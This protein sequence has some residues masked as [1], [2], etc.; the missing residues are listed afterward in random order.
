LPKFTLLEL[1]FFE[2][3]SVLATYVVSF[4]T[5]FLR[6]VSDSPSRSYF[7]TNTDYGPKPF[8]I[9]ERTWSPYVSL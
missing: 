2:L 1:F 5:N 7:N 3:F 4:N 8:C 9:D 6:L